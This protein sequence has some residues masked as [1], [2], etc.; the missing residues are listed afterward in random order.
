MYKKSSD[1]FD[2]KWQQEYL[3]IQ[4]IFYGMFSIHGSFKDI[5]QFTQALYMFFLYSHAGHMFVCRAYRAY[6]F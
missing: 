6:D 3:N 5:R 4:N 1:S 2:V